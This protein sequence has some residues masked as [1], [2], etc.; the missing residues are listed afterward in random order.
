MA[1]GYYA[2]ITVDHTKVSG[3][4]DLTNFPIL[5]SGT[6][7]GTGSEPDFR[8]VA[9]G[10]DIENVDTTGGNSGL[11]SVP[12]D[13]AFYNNT[14]RTIQYDHEIESYDA[15]T[16][17]LVAHV[18]IPT[19]DGDA[20]TTFYV[21]YGDATVTTSQENITGVWESNYKGV[22]HLNN[23]PNSGGTIYDSTSSPANMTS[24]GSMVS[25]DLVDA[26]VG[27]GITF[28]KSKSQYLKTA[29]SV[30]KLDITG[31]YTL[32]GIT[33]LATLSGQVAIVLAHGDGTAYWQ[34]YL[35]FD[36]S[37]SKLTLLSSGGGSITES[38]TSSTATNY[39]VVGIRSGTTGYLRKNG[40]QV[41]T[42]SG[43]NNPSSR[44]EE[45]FHANND[46][47]PS[48]MYLDGTTSELRISNSARSTDWCDTTYETLINPSTFYTMGNATINTV[49]SGTTIFGD[50]GQF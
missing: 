13:L 28:E 48:Q 16:G 7:D 43:F 18:R 9:N 20:N 6:Y 34:W 21:H 12:A 37:N 46:Y 32:E 42:G 33:N 10:G 31:D 29:T 39:H 26:A 23:D 5:I 44:T 35:T 38:G 17:K 4:G 40:S 27:K 2:E 49:A 22:W 47:A 15:T 8:T 36:N 24:Q 3:T 30:A 19:L 45:I 14:S 11:L 50:E 25:G 1:Y 41:G